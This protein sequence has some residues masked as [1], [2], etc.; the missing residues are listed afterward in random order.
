M[1]IMHNKRGEF[2]KADGAFTSLAKYAKRFDADSAEKVLR[3]HPELACMRYDAAP[4]TEGYRA[5]QLRESPAFSHVAD[6][7]IKLS[8]A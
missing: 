7:L 1:F 2:L 4:H 3:F 8:A 6:S 5:E